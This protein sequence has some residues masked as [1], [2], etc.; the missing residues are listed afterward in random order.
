M[1]DLPERHEAAIAALVRDNPKIAQKVASLRA[2]IEVRYDGLDAQFHAA[3]LRTCVEEWYS[4]GIDWERERVKALME[5]DRP[6]VPAL[7][8]LVLEAI[9]SGKS[10]ADIFDAALLAMEGKH[11]AIQTPNVKAL[12]KAARAFGKAIAQEKR[13]LNGR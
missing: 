9:A 11:S 5:L 12:D 1:K 4:Q 2:A 6:E 7:H 3:L 8:K 10:T 13:G